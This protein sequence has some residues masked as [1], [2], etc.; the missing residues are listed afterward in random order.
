[1]STCESKQWCHACQCSAKNFDKTGI[2][3]RIKPRKTFQWLLMK[4]WKKPSRSRIRGK[5]NDKITI[6]TADEIELMRIRRVYCKSFLQCF[7]DFIV[8]GVSHWN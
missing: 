7:D 3:S 8:P 5:K 2:Q 6:K 1:M 4:C